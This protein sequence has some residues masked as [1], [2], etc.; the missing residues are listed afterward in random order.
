MRGFWYTVEAIIAVVILIFF[1]VAI[2]TT[3]LRGA[4]V[5][6][7]KKGYEILKG[8]DEQGIL[9]SYVENEDPEGL[10]SQIDLPGFNHTVQICDTNEVCVGTRPTQAANI[11]VA[12]Y[13]VSGDRFYSPHN[14]ILYIFI[15][16]TGTTG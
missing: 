8:L 7:S 3:L 9:R 2:G 14:V 13:L 12:N 6:I 11:F 1:L 4:P 15:S 5:D 10:N 16:V